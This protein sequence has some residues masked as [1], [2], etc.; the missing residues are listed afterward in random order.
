MD[1]KRKNPKTCRYSKLIFNKIK[2]N[3]QSFNNE[4]LRI[5]TLITKRESIGKNYTV[6]IFVTKKL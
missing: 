4:K 5:K 1:L 2:T 6:T 3:I